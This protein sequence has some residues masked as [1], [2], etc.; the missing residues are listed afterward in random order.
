MKEGWEY[1][2]FEDA[3]QTVKYTKKVQSSD[4][5]Q[6]GLIPIISQEEDLISGYWNNADD[7][8]KVDAP[9]VIFGD[10]SRVVKY[11]DCDFVLGA[12]GVKIL[13]P[14]KNLNARYLY[15]YLK[16]YKVPSLGYSRH[17][18]LLKEIILPIPPLSEQKHIFEELDL[19]SNIIDKKKVQLQEL[20]NLAQSIYYEMFGNPIINEKGWMIS[21]VKDLGKV[22]TGNTPSRKIPQY[23]DSEY[24]EW[25]KTDN[26]LKDSLYATRAKE[27][28]SESGAVQGRT[29]DKG[30]LLVACIAGSIDSIGKVC[31][32]DRNVAFNQQINAII[33]NKDNDVLFLY[34]TIVLMGGYIREHATSGMKHIITKSAMEALLFPIPPLNL[35]QQF[36]RKIEAIEHQKELI[37]QSIKEVE[38]LLNSRM[39]YYFN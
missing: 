20:D 18:K 19:L 25:I 28:L 36:A 3:L 21:T 22:I 1:L 35:Q 29:V 6:E 37:K 7:S 9:V 23:Y 16:W 17:Y 34:Y 13:K 39:D 24:I 30:A 33:P 4:Y 5:L 15:H 31:V 8:F 32:T 12:D 14:K 38:T 11:V 27:Y 2:K 26:I 10:H